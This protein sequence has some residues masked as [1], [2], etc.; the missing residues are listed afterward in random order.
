VPAENRSVVP[1]EEVLGEG[2]A[3]QLSLVDPATDPVWAQL[4]SGPGGSLFCA[5]PWI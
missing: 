5:P 4:A 2:G 3:G 1:V